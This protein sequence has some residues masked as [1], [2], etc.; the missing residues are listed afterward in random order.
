MVFGKLGKSYNIWAIAYKFKTE[1]HFIIPITYN[2]YTLG[3]KQ[4]L[5][6]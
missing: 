1:V 6:A 4:R 5:M 3:G 2:R